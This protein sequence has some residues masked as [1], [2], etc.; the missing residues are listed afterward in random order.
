LSRELK[1][2]LQIAAGRVHGFFDPN[3]SSENS[4]IEFFAFGN[5]FIDGIMDKMLRIPNSGVGGRIAADIESGDHLEIVYQFRFGGVRPSAKIVRFVTRNSGP[6]MIEEDK[7]IDLSGSPIA[8]EI[9]NWVNSRFSEVESIVEQMQVD[10]RNQSLAEFDGI[11]S[12]EKLRASRVFDQLRIRNQESLDTELIWWNANKD[13]VDPKIQKVLPARKGR[14]SKLEKRISSVELELESA[15]AM[16]EM[17]VPEIEFERM[18][19]SMI[20]GH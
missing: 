18:W 19:I 5:R 2:D 7:K 20:R 11:Q 14:I 6:M 16:I 10:F 13:S 4:E 15:L 1:I 12:E 9:P 8:I 3:F 17:K